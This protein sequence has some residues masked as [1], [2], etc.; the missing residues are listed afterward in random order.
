MT[1]RVEHD[2]YVVL[3]L[4]LRQRGT[5][6][7]GPSDARLKIIYCDVQMLLNLRL[8]AHA[9]PSRRT[10]PSRTRSS[11]SVLARVWRRV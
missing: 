5:D 7:N 3:R 8:S 2:P 10:C 6:L 9:W 11:A 1:R 4:V